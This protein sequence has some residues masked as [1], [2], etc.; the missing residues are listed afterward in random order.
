MTKTKKILL[1]FGI[2]FILF[3]SFVYAENVTTNNSET[4]QA[5]AV[6]ADRNTTNT[7]TNTSYNNNGET[8]STTYAPTTTPYNSS[9][10]PTPTSNVHTSVS[11]ITTIPESGLGL[12]NILNI[13]LI[14]IGVLLILFAVAILIKA[15]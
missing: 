13:F 10:N 9:T 2:V 11:H 14:V 3:S 15:K 12:T 1:I 6:P 7:S 8:V 4:P 5:T